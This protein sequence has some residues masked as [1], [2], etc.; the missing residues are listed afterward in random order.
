MKENGLRVKNFSGTTVFGSLEEDS[1][2]VISNFSSISCRRSPE[3][4]TT[5]EKREAT[6]QPQNK[7]KRHIEI[8]VLKNKKNYLM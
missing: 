1:R 8:F 6:T 7:S 5:T 4:V 2:S 3:R